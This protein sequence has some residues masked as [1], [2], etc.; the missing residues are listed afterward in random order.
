MPNESGTSA[1][2]SVVV[3]ARE[4]NPPVQS[5]GKPSLHA[6]TI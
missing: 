2:T 5:R 4:A 1:I 3:A 6:E